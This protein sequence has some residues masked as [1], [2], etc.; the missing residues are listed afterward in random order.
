MSSGQVMA[1]LRTVPD[2]VTDPKRIGDLNI[3]WWDRLGGA[4]HHGAALA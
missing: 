4:A 1:L 2:P 3:R